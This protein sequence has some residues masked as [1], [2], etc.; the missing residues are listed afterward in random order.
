MKKLIS[1]IILCL[2]TA[3]TFGVRAE[4]KVSEVFSSHM[5]LQREKPVK[6]WGTADAG[7]KVKV[8]FGK[9]SL[10]TTADN[11]GCWQVTLKAMVASSKPQVM[12]VSG[13]K[14]KVRLTDILVGEVWLASGQSNMEYSMNDHPKYKKPQKGDPDYQLKAWREADNPNIRVLYV[15]RDIKSRALPTDGWQHVDSTSLKPVS[16]AAY[17]FA[18]MLQDSLQVPVGFISSSWGGTF[19]EEWTPVEEMKGETEIM[20]LRKPLF[21]KL[22]KPMAGYAL[23]GF[24]WY[25][26]E[27]NLMDLRDM[28]S[29]TEKQEHLVNTWRMLWNDDDLFFYYVQISP[30]LY[31]IRREDIVQKTWIDLPRFWTAQ[32]EAMRQKNTGM[33]VTTDIPDILTD[34]HPPYKWIVGERLCRWALNRTYGFKHVECQGPTLKNTIRQGDKVILEFDHCDGGL[35]TSD[36]KEPD[37]FWANTRNHGSFRKEKAIIDGNNIILNIPEKLE[38]PI[39]RFGYDETAQPNL[40]NRAGLPAMPFEIEL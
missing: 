36:G 16:A 39:I 26:G 35:V 8:T 20:D 28:D 11:Q 13:R 7:E 12:T 34:I 3:C 25:Q 23:R 6:V 14:N 33:V 37:W 31:S 32:T 9:Q 4:V 21:E 24:L 30:Y 2:L 15:R 5:V 29:Y 17:F 19:I 1:M 18:K 10:S 27:A 22:I 40:S 38:H